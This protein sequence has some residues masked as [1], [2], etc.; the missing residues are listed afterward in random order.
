MKQGDVIIITGAT[1]GIGLACARLFYQKGYRLALAARSLDVLLQI[2]K[3]LDPDGKRVAVVQAD[4]GI[5][6]DCKKIIDH[7]LSVFGTIHVLMNNAGITMRALF[8]EVDLSVMHK[9]MEVNFWGAVHCTHYALPELLKNRGSVIGVSSVAGYKGL[10]T[11]TGYS[12]SK[13]ALEGFLETLRI[14]NL[15]SGLH[16]LI[17]RPG[18]TATNIRNTMMDARGQSQGSSHKDEARSMTPEYVAE[19]IFKS[20]QKRKSYMLLS[21]TAI[22]TFWLNKFFPA[23]VDRQVFRHV[24]KEK[25]SPLK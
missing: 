13:F 24:Q 17:A 16:V 3:E 9:I 7:T 2:Q 20:V 10:P 22:L 14:E 6:Q 1:S 4:V 18:F 19:G 8:K 25:D 11:R 15:K 23:W 5:E 21:T 12:A